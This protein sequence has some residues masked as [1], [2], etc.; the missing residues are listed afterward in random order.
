MY[1]VQF[2]SKAN[3]QFSKLNESLQQRIINILERIKFRPYHFIKKKEGTKY[4]ILR[5]GEYRIILDIDNN[6]T[7]IFVIELGHRK[8]IYK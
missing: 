4:F 3:E 7:I 6:K 5:V 8:N 1:H 2:A